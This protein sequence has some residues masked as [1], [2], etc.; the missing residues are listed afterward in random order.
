MAVFTV[1]KPVSFA[2]VDNNNTQNDNSNNKTIS[3]LSSAT[4]INTGY[5]AYYT[6]ALVMLASFVFIILLRRRDSI[7]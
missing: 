3:S 5:K 4:P 6:V 1:A 2:L 7:E